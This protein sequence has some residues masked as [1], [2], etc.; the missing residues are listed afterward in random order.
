MARQI[1][2]NPKHEIRIPEQKKGKIEFLSS[3][4]QNSKQSDFWYLNLEFWICLEFRN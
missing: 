2:A 3:N 4:G 1:M